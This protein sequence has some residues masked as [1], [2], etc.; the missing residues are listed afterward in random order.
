M[1]AYRPACVSSKSPLIKLF[2][3]FRVRS[4]KLSC[5]AH[6]EL[7][8]A[9]DRAC[10]FMRTE[11][12][13]WLA[14][15]GCVRGCRASHLSRRSR[16]S[17]GFSTCIGF[18]KA[19]RT[20]SV[21]VSAGISRSVLLAHWSARAVE[22]AAGNWEQLFIAIQA[23]WENQMRKYTLYLSSLPS[24]LQHCETIWR[25]RSHSFFCACYP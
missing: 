9:L 17:P 15:S 3:V 23:Q 2:R 5:Q 12:N 14:S 10:I 25:T 19:P 13:D 24:S 8:Y 6:P 22:T 7:F 21:L 16:T 1:A 11:C 20:R 18:L 4:L